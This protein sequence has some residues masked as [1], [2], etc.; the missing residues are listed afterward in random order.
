MSYS[1]GYFS[2]KI[3]GKLRIGHFLRE[4]I[5]QDA[6]NNFFLICICKKFKL[7]SGKVINYFQRGVF[8]KINFNNYF[9][10]K[11]S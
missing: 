11:W 1:K 8:E 7:S 5:F 2:L 6:V 4:G 3:E 10:T 9:V